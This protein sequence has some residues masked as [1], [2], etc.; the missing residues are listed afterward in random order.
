MCPKIQVS[1]I[2]YAAKIFS[3]FDYMIAILDVE[4]KKFD[5]FD[6]ARPVVEHL[7]PNVPGKIIIS[8]QPGMEEQL[9]TQEA[10]RPRA[11]Y[12]MD[13]KR[14][15]KQLLIRGK[16]DLAQI[17]FDADAN[18]R[19]ARGYDVGDHEYVYYYRDPGE[20]KWRDVM[21][22][23]EDNFELWHED[24]HGFDPAVPGN[25]LVSAFNGDD[26]MGLWSFNTRTKSYDELLYR[27]SD[28]DVSGVRFHSNYWS[29]P[30]EV[31]GVAYFKDNFHFEYFDEIEG[32]TF[33]QLEE[34]IPY[35][36]YVTIPSRSRDG[37]RGGQ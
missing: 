32:A 36:H 34:L 19:L 31:T 4:N 37:N 15:S 22:V 29:K 24:V 1:C 13:L 11:Y 7:L 28:V 12:L 14:G 21:R 20:G 25:L 3:D 23:S 6:A 18:P 30:D 35:A 2:A 10:F 5:D 27:R 16:W 33:R 17:E 8:E 9:T 26:K